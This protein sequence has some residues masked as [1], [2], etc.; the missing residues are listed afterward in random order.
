M[1][2][3]LVIGALLP[4]LFFCSAQALAQA[5]VPAGPPV[6]SFAPVTGVPIPLQSVSGRFSSLN[7]LN[8]LN[9]PYKRVSGRVVSPRLILVKEMDC[10]RPGHDNV[11]VNIQLS[12]P[13]DAMEMVTGRRVTIAA[14]FKN[15]EEDRDPIFVAEFL[16]AEQA[17]LVAGDPL[18]HSAPPA[19]AFTSYMLCQPPE[20]DALAT[21]LGKELCVQ[22][23]I[24]A[25]LTETGPAL[26]T[27]ARAPAKL[28]PEDTVPGDRNAISCR[29]DPG[30]SDRH[31]SAIACARNSYWVWYKAKWR[32]PLSSTPAPP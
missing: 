25:D 24:V 3:I 29:L 22:S 32:D 12:N 11:L 8:Q 19:R 30:V 17:K 27:A 31:L 28:S 13:A 23:T 9:C 2:P 1:K 7:P 20:L 6:A 4:T 18:D 15:A 16:I 21:R 10:G 5:R 14:R 26:E